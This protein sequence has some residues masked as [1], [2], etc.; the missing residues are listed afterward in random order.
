MNS[1]SLHRWTRALVLLLLLSIPLPSAVVLGGEGD[2]TVLAPQADQPRTTALIL[3]L[4]GKTHYRRLV[5]DDALSGRLLDRYLSYLDPGRVHFLAADISEFEALRKSLDDELEDQDLGA[6]FRIFNRFQVRRIERL[7]YLNGVV[8]R[9]LAKLDLGADESILTDREEVAWPKDIAAARDL[10]RRL[11]RHAV[12]EIN[13]LQHFR[14]HGPRLCGGFQNGFKL[15]AFAR[16]QL[17]V[18]FGVDQ[19]QGTCFQH[20]LR[21]LQR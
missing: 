13:E 7:E 2:A 9:D 3:R 18:D 4:L 5:V 14:L 12:E 19:L 21:P 20:G 8:A 1:S 16:L 11:L 10:W 15:G 17:S 6:A